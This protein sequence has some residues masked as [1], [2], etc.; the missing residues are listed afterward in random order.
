M[1]SAETLTSLSKFMTACLLPEEYN[2]PSE[3]AEL[4]VLSPRGQELVDSVHRDNSGI[5]EADVKAASL[6][7]YA[8]GDVLLI[9]AEAT[10]DEALCSLLTR[11][12]AE[13]RIRYPWVYGRQLDRHYAALYAGAAPVNALPA[14][15]S[16]RLL[17]GVPQGVAQV[18]DMIIGPFGI[19]RSEELRFSPPMSCGPSYR[20]SVIGCTVAHHVRL[21]TGT[22]PAGTFFRQLVERYPPTERTSTQVVDWLQ[23][24]DRA[25]DPFNTDSLSWLLGNGLTDSEQ[26]S[27]LARLVTRVS[28][29]TVDRLAAADLLGQNRRQFGAAVDGLDSAQVLQ[30]LLTFS[31]GDIASHLEGLV[32]SGEIKLSPGEIRL[33]V[34]QRHARGGGAFDTTIE[35]SRAGLRLR[36]TLRVP[37]LRTFLRAIYRAEQE[38]LDYLLRDYPGTSPFDR[39]DAF[40]RAVD[41]R[42]VLRRLVFVSRSTLLRAFDEV[43][44]GRLAVP[45]NDEESH[46]LEARLLWKLGGAPEPPASPDARLVQFGNTFRAAIAAAPVEPNEE[47]FTSVR[48]AGMDFFVE[49]EAVLTSTVAFTGWLLT[50]DHFSQWQDRYRFSRARAQRWTTRLLND[51]QTEGFSFNERGNPMGT[52]LQAS[53]MLADLTEATLEH[54]ADYRRARI[55]SYAAH[56]EAQVFPFRHTRLACDLADPAAQEIVAALRSVQSQFSRGDV[57]GTRNR[58]GHPPSTFPTPEELGRALEGALAGIG[59]GH[60]LGLAPT[61]YRRESRS[62]DG[63]GREIRVM[64]DGSGRALNLYGPSEVFM[65]GM[66]PGDVQLVIV[67][68]AVLRDTSQPMCFRLQDDTEFAELWSDYAGLDSSESHGGQ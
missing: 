6:A 61:V 68:G 21:T 28:G 58:L 16:Y 8:A 31:T 25:Y 49:A 24:D 27:L 33:P 1:G 40:L 18:R 4:I 56:T 29:G 32:D 66:P 17:D 26:K 12:I 53:G 41:G 50:F 10:N 48:S 43:R 38:D 13:K 51:A 9:N 37:L 57:A 47:W 46:A 60:G 52:L 22:T 7:S 23:P 67:P 64:R 62:T 36:P 35:L 11:E 39:L 34:L 19:L 3:L 59:N 20:C 63:L 55:P 5:G 30:L 2:F 54:E 65:S 44:F 42:E 45:K 14:G 15:Q